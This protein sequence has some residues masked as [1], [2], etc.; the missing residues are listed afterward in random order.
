[1]GTLRS[2]VHGKSLPLTSPHSE[3]LVLDNIRLLRRSDTTSDM[4]VPIYIRYT[5]RSI[6]STDG[7]AAF[8]HLHP[9]V[10]IR[11]PHIVLHSRYHPSTFRLMMHLRTS[12]LSLPQIA[13]PPCCTYDECFVV[14]LKLSLE[15]AT[16]DYHSQGPRVKAGAPYSELDLHL[17]LPFDQRTDLHF[18]KTIRQ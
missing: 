15:S 4:S 12:S 7:K 10:P 5:Q 1:M 16:H 17:H 9:A 18:G 3:T 8:H 11:I 13:Y 2:E 14:Q 6:P